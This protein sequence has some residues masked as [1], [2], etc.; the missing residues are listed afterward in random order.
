MTALCMS[1]KQTLGRGQALSRYE[2]G[3]NLSSQREVC[4]S[5]RQSAQREVLKLWG[6]LQNSMVIPADDAKTPIVNK[7]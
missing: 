5:S 1:E 4:I 3:D 2:I 7:Y 6:R